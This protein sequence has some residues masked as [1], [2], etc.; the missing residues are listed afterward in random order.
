MGRA[1][2]PSPESSA[3]VGPHET[4]E[5]VI[6]V[7]TRASIDEAHEMITACF[8]RPMTVISDCLR[9]MICAAPGHEL[10]AADFANIEGRVL[11]WLAGNSGSS[12]RS[13]P[14]TRRKARTFIN[15]DTKIVPD[16]R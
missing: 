15:W 1:S 12:T 7:L 10:M 13:P 9:G 14:T 16:S 2:Y 3:S 8:D 11:A 4:I 6:D 5:Q